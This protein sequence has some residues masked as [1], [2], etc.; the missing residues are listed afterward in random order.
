[1]AKKDTKK[2]TKKAE[3][4]EKKKA[5][6]EV[7]DIEVEEK[8]EKKE[9]PE[10]KTKLPQNILQVGDHVEQDKK[11]YINQSTYKKIQ[12]FTRNKTKVE[13]GGIL[14]GSV[15]E[16]MGQ[17]NIMIEGFIEGKDSE[18]TATTLTFTHKTWDYVHQQREKKFPKKQIVGWI[19]THPDFGIFL[20][21]YDKFIHENFFS[22][23]NQ[24]AYV[25]DPIQ[26]EEGFYFWINEKLERCTGFYVY[27][28]V[29]ADLQVSL[30]EKKEETKEVGLSKPMTVLVG[31]LCASVVLLAI[32]N[33]AMTR[34]LN[35]LERKTQV[36]ETNMATRDQAISD[37]LASVD[38]VMNSLNTI[39]T[40]NQD[41]V[42]DI[43]N[44][45]D[46]IWEHEG[47]PALPGAEETQEENP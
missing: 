12:R 44:K 6:E 47:Y 20:S 1:M 34:K 25:V 2:T 23:E 45:I 30:P 18:G 16:E 10:K 21:D 43:Q 31:V 19:H 39:V 28:K 4:V 33:I 17:Q 41:A 38:T 13:S 32:S 42:T 7:V 9:K 37:A 14:I 46:F 35:R 36:I 11:I 24:V 3:K 40:E 29:G 22:G 15:I 8:T 27:D 5:T 26:G